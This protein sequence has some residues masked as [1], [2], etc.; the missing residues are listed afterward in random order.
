MTAIDRSTEDREVCEYLN[1][2]DELANR[3]ALA[4]AMTW[5]AADSSVSHSRAGRVSG[6]ASLLPAPNS[7]L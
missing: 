2:M 7:A 3:D 1:D 6:V 4:D 5:S